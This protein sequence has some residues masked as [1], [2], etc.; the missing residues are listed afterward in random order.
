MLV[1][2]LYSTNS[3][4]QPLTHGLFISRPIFCHQSANF[5]LI[6]D[7]LKYLY[8]VNSEHISNWYETLVM[9]LQ[10]YFTFGEVTE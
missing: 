6:Y 1:S 10:T 9:Y 2:S 8:I 7:N 3:P 5:L 4:T